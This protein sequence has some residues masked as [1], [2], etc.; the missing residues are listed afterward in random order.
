MPTITIDFPTQKKYDDLKDAVCG[1][2]IY[3]D[4][5][6]EGESEDDFLKRMIIELLKKESRS[7]RTK[8][9]R[10][11]YGASVAQAR[12]DAQNDIDGITIN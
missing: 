11:S 4:N 3:E 1:N 7:Y 9:A 6:T 12:I 5:K 10:D 8:Q 2:R